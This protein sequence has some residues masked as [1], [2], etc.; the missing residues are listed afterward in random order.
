F[1]LL[2]QMISGE[3]DCDR[4]DYLLRDSYYC[5]VS[6]GQYDLDWIIENLEIANINQNACLAISERALTTFDDFLLSRFHMFIMVYFHYRA[7]CL[8]KMMYR[9]FEEANNEYQIPAS[10]HEYI[11]HDDHFL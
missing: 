5:G 4:M 1:P 8:E 2:H 7:V 3:M 10:I 9:Y 11:I 6:Y